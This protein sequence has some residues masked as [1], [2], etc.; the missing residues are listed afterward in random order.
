MAGSGHDGV[1]RG[2]GWPK[3][4]REGH[5]PTPFVRLNVLSLSGWIDVDD[6]SAML[7]HDEELDNT[8]RL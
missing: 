8:N 5:E 1:D 2:E 7:G 6:T 3:R 4:G